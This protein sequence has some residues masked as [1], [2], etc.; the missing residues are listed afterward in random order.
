VIVP[1]R[2]APTQVIAPHGVVDGTALDVRNA[3]LG[4]GGDM[5]VGASGAKA[6]EATI[7]AVTIRVT[8]A[9]VA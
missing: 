2:A 3:E 5:W 1:A 4:G 8:E 9:L 6:E 7:D